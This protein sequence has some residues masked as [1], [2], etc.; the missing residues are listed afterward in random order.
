MSDY[1]GTASMA[2][3]SEE[4]FLDSGAITCGVTYDKTQMTYDK[5]QMTD[6]NRPIAKSQSEMV[7]RF[8]RKDKAQSC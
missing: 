8:L 3:Q 5:T 7:T 4:W 6:M 2:G 1:V